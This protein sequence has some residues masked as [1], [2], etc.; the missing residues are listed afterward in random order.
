MIFTLR[1]GPTTGP[2]FAARLGQ[3]RDAVEEQT[4]SSRRCVQTAAI[5]KVMI[6]PRRANGERSLWHLTRS[7]A[8]PL[9]SCCLHKDC[10]QD[11]NENLRVP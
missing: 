10:I 3:P 4:F 9:V 2:S 6:R 1:C 5:V 7:D 8:D 11:T